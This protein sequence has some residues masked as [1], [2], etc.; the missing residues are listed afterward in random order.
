M[1]T[2]KVVVPVVVSWLAQI[3]LVILMSI[4]TRSVNQ[5]MYWFILIVPTLVNL[6][7]LL[8]ATNRAERVLQNIMLV[9][10]GAECLVGLI[11][12]VVN[13]HYYSLIRGGIV[14]LSIIGLVMVS[15]VAF[16]MIK[17]QR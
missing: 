6:P 16:Q 11:A 9:L 4:A 1:N 12:I 14:L 5:K 10:S 17:R 13:Q 3:G 8:R 15:V 7:L 2:K